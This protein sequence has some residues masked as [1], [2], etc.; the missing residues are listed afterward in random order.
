[1]IANVAKDRKSEELILDQLSRRTVATSSE[2]IH[3]LA[4]IGLSA[5]AARKAL[6]RAASHKE[7]WRSERLKLSRGERLFAKKESLN[8][9]EFFRFVGE[10]LSGSK[11]PGMSRCVMSLADKPILNH[12]D[13]MKLLGVPY[14]SAP[15]ARRKSIE[16]ELAA[17]QEIGCKLSN[18]DTPFESLVL[19]NWVGDDE[20]LETCVAETT[21][22]QRKERLI[23]SI[24]V[25]QL[26]NQG[27]I[28]WS[29]GVDM[30]MERPY[31]V[32]NNF[33]FTAQ[34]YSYLRP[35]VLTK[36][37]K[38]S[39]CPVLIDVVSG[40]ASIA[41]VDSFTDRVAKATKGHRTR[42][43]ALLAADEFSPEAWNKAKKAGLWGIGLKQTFG[44]QAL[45]AMSQIESLVSGL[46]SG[47]LQ[48]SETKFEVF[49]QT[50]EELKV[51]PV[52]AT[53][54]S[55]G[56]EILAGLVLY[57]KQYQAIEISR[58]VPWKKSELREVDAYGLN[59]GC[60]YVIECKASRG[61]KSVTDVEVR[62]F[63]TETLP[64][65]KNWLRKE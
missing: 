22:R 23:A 37:G 39:P 19:P 3:Q 40:A 9:R 30:N 31:S 2:L 57:A 32:F 12:V 16:E 28:A 5:N 34:C 64:A 36:N 43:I 58:Q 54:R 65:L 53:L 14:S 44:E 26:Q 20:T 61:N 8:S 1:M 47:S 41:D 33:I 63:F 62:K 50:L 38:T 24:I 10:A 48:E 52:V 7:V 15:N 17:L 13:L 45:D 46:F 59:D 18:S 4:K 25:T 55:I 6:S 11:R 21:L 60:L 56:L 49:S 29:S 35:L 27:V 51:H 42:S